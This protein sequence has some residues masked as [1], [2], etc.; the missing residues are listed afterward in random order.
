[1]QPWPRAACFDHIMLLDEKGV[2]LTFEVDIAVKDVVF[3]ITKVDVGLSLQAI[4]F[5]GRET[6]LH[7]THTVGSGLGPG[8]V[9]STSFMCTLFQ[10]RIKVVLTNKQK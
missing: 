7:T 10:K 5:V 8:R 2:L 3:P 6:G 9:I 4:V 1:M